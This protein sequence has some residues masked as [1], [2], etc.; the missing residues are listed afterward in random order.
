VEN[1][2]AAFQRAPPRVVGKAGST[3]YD[4]RA[5]RAPAAT[6]AQNLLLLAGHDVAVRVEQSL[7]FLKHSIFYLHGIQFLRVNK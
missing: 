7:G 1:G 4:A 2:G 5:V 6:D 3:A